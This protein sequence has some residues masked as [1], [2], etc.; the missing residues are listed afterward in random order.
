LKLV[1]GVA[2]APLLPSVDRDCKAG[3]TAIQSNS[4][5]P[6]GRSGESG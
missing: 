6:G 4:E 2:S 1:E 3:F 5:A